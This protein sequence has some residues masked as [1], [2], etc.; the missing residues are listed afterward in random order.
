MASFLLF[1]L[2]ETWKFEGIPMLGSSPHPHSILNASSLLHHPILTPSSPHPHSI[3]T[4]FQSTLRSSGGV[5][6]L[7]LQHEHFWGSPHFSIAP[8]CAYVKTCPLSRGFGQG[9]S[10]FYPRTPMVHISCRKGG[11]SLG[12]CRVYHKFLIVS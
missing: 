6:F 4:P 5:V 7:G 3:L 8:D 2:C 12:P 10:P 1:S 11:G 9:L